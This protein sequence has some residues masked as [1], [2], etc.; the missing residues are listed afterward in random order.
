MV[1]IIKLTNERVFMFPLTPI[2]LLLLS[3]WGLLPFVFYFISVFGFYV[4]FVIS[5]LGLL[6]VCVCFLFSRLLL[7][8][9]FC[10]I[11]FGL[12]N[13]GKFKLF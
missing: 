8:H 7:L 6:P 13:A 9:A 12:T 1:A 2:S 4:I 3:I 10:L 5:F 11:F